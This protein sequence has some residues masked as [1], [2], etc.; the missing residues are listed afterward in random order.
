MHSC[1]QPAQLNKLESMCVIRRSGRGGAACVNGPD[2]LAEHFL[3]AFRAGLC[4][5]H[6]DAVEMQLLW[7]VA[8][9]HAAV[10]HW[11]PS[12]HGFEEKCQSREAHHWWCT[13]GVSMSCFLRRSNTRREAWMRLTP[14]A[15]RISA[16][17]ASSSCGASQ[18]QDSPIGALIEVCR[19]Q[20]LQLPKRFSK[21]VLE[22]V[23]LS[24]VR[25]PPESHLT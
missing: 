11:L 13:T 19:V 23:S 22:P 2:S 5:A 17:V 10:W 9:V 24:A 25:F 15:V 6:A 20:V 12:T 1:S 21:A 16:I 7:N 14:G 18:W 8:Y 3:H 4:L